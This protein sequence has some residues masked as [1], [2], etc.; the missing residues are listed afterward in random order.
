MFKLKYETGIVTFIQFIVLSILNFINQLVSVVSTC[1]GQSSDC[2]SNSISSITLMILVVVWFGAVWMI[3]YVAQ[4][5]HSRRLARLLILAEMAV[6]VI[7]LFNLKHP[8]NT[9]GSV[10]SLIDLLL[11]AWVIVLA[12]RIYRA[13]GGRVVT[14]TRARRR[15]Q[16]SKSD[17][18]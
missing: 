7:E 6:I 11:A 18:L 12:W 13:K 16:P 2:V 3:G 14:S 5:R 1:H 10:T 15:R 9:L 8:A 17:E 4:D